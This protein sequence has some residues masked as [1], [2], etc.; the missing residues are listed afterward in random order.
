M[1]GVFGDLIPTPPDE[2]RSKAW[3]FDLAVNRMIRN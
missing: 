2:V 1:N 3:F